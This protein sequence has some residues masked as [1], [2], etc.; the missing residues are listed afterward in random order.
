MTRASAIPADLLT[1]LGAYLRLRGEGGGSFLLESVERGRL[2]RNSFVGWGARLVGLEEAETL[3]TPV[4]GYVSYDHAAK[5]EPTVPVPA[6]GP[7]S[8]KAVSSSPRRSSAS[9]TARESPRS[10][11]VSRRTSPASWQSRL[12]RCEAGDGERGPLRRFPSQSRYE[13]MVR[14]VPGLHPS[15]R[16]L[17][18]R[19]V[20]ARRAADVG[21]A[22]RALP[23]ASQGQ[24]LAVSLPARARRARPRRL[25]PRAACRLRGRTGERLP[26]RGYDDA[27]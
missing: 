5:L 18:D 15:R 7:T 2:G 6:D 16:R 9:I 26:H 23:R 8:R 20:T 10:S 13:E 21:I 24:P 11:R 17:S 4:V 27:G 25:V 1:P 12:Q 22:A 14:D 3:E 19:P